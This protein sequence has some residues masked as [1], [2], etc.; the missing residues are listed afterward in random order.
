MPSPEFVVKPKR[1]FSAIS[2]SPNLAQRYRASKESSHFPIKIN[3]TNSHFTEHCHIDFSVTSLIIPFA[4][5]K[6]K[7]KTN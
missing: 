4:M 2:L 3:T 5:R 7:I 6:E 1:T